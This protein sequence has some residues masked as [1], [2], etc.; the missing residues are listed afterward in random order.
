MRQERCVRVRVSAI[1]LV[2]KHIE[3]E[4]KN[5]GGKE[6]GYEDTLD[7]SVFCYEFVKRKFMHTFRSNESSSSPAT[8][9][10]V[11]DP[12]E[13]GFSILASFSKESR[14]ILQHRVGCCDNC[15]R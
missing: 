5:K 3:A 7:M 14:H 8:G 2:A 12:S 15:L 10:Y 11:G 6:E 9:L 13:E 4:G 1:Y